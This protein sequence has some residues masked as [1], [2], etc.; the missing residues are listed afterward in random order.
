MK[1][2]VN[3]HPFFK[4]EENKKTEEKQRKLIEDKTKEQSI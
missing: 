2:M 3:F 4:T 1:H